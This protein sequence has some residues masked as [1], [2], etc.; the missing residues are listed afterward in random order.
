VNK[1]TSAKMHKGCY[2]GISASNFWYGL[3][4]ISHVMCINTT[5]TTVKAI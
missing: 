5:F 2:A 4:C 3:K 1:Q